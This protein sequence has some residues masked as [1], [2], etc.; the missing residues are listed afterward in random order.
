MVDFKSSS[1]LPTLTFGLSHSSPTSTSSLVING[2]CSD[3]QPLPSSSLQICVKQGGGCFYPTDFI[4][5]TDCSSGSYSFPVPAAAI[6][7]EGS[8]QIEALVSDSEGNFSIWAGTTIADFVIDRT[9]PSV[10]VSAASL[11]LASSLDTITISISYPGAVSSTLSLSDITISYTGTVSCNQNL[12]QVGFTPSTESYNLTLSNCIGTGT[13]SIASIAAAQATDIALNPDLGASASS[14]FTVDNTAPSSF[15]ISGITG[16]SDV[17]VDDNLNS[18]LTPNV[19]WSPSTNALSYDVTVYEADGTTLRC[20]TVNTV[21]TSHNFSACPLVAGSQYRVRVESIRYAARTIASNNLYAFLVNRPPVIS[22]DT[23][24]VSRN[25]VSISFSGAAATPQAND[26]DLDGHSLTITSVGGAANGT[27]S[28]ITGI[29]SYQ[30]NTGFHGRDS[31]SYS[32]SDSRGGD[33]TGT[34]NV[35]VVAPGTWLGAVSS[36]WSNSGNWCGGPTTNLSACSPGTVPSAG[37]VVLFDD[38]CSPFCNANLTASVTINMIDLSAS[39]NGTL[40]LGIF[41]LTV[42]GSEGFKQAGGAVQ[43][44]TGTIAV[45]LG[46]LVVQGGIFT[47]GTGNIT[48]TNGAL[49]LQGG[50]FTAPTGTLSTAVANFIAGSTFNHNNGVFK[51][52]SS[53]SGPASH[54]FQTSP[55]FYDFIMS[56]SGSHTGHSF[57]STE[58]YVLNNLAFG[59][60]LSGRKFTSGTIHF[61]GTQISNMSTR[62]GYG[63]KGLIRFIGTSNQN[64]TSDLLPLVLPSV[65]IAKTAGTLSFSSFDSVIDGDFIFTSGTIDTAASTITFGDPLA[66]IN[67]NT[68]IDPGAVNFY[69]LNFSNISNPAIYNRTI[70]SPITVSNE[71]RFQST[72]GQR[73]NGAKL[74][75]YGNVYFVSGGAVGT[76]GIE[77]AGPSNTSL[78][79]SASSVLGGNFDLNKAGATLTTIGALNLSTAGQD[80]HLMSGI[81]SLGGGLV[82]SDTLILDVGTILNGNANSISYGAL[83]NAG[84]INP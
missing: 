28:L 18:V 1:T 21:T 75:A 65:E 24:F 14:L 70:N 61:S 52:A 6:A 13:A 51:L 15:V 81:L 23:Y 71:L 5:L 60:L 20:A 72:A 59:S 54:T 83:S 49:T 68:I 46:S 38:I 56:G 69:N 78:F 53:F 32:I 35:N 62:Y 16:G 39:Y 74:I 41:P 42:T 40:S 31:F 77:F 82:V 84:T 79:N 76:S 7:S 36:S 2:G 43:C 44:G 58:I 19:S 26:S 9:G 12:T 8:Y 29:V 63:G 66:A 17:V 64:F 22:F 30:P 48:I 34:I 67:A 10:S 57:S 47:G 33:A 50:I 25:T 4:H 37:A 27:T 45:N 80:F 73:I 55:T 3:D 11:S